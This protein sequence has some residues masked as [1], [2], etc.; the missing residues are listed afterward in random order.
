MLSRIDLT[1]YDILLVWFFLYPLVF[2][3]AMMTVRYK[4]FFYDSTGKMMLCLM[5]LGSILVLG[6]LSTLVIGT[7]GIL[8][9]IY[10]SEK[11]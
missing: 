1:P 2:I 11:R 7:L 9:A 10:I 6:F 3:C 5:L 4:D 8:T